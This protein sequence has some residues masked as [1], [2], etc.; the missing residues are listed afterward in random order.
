MVEK[1]E[2]SD[3]I[4]ITDT[5]LPDGAVSSIIDD[6]ALM[7]ERCVKNMDAERQKAIIKWVT[8][9]MIASGPDKVRTSEKLG[10]ASESF[11]T[12][13]LGKGLEGSVYGQ[14]A[15]ALDDTGCLNRIGRPR[16]TFGVI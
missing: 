14:Q 12:A 9:H 4:A 11:A 13:Q 5:D 15:L 7:V 8:A 3:V 1:P 6:A 2:A 16:A 10:D